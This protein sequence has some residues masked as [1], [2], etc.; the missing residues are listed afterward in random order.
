MNLKLVSKKQVSDDSYIF[1]FEL[2]SPT[3]QLGVPIGQHLKL[4]QQLSTQDF[5]A[6]EQVERK[7]TPVTKLDTKGVM[8]LLVKV[9][10]PGQHP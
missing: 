3:Q 5:P 7:Y 8:E 10:M 6:G 9:Y 4:I 1:T 2:P